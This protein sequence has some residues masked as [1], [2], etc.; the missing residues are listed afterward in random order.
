VVA[1]LR[2]TADLLDEASGRVGRSEVGGPPHRRERRQ[3]PSATA[4]QRA[5]SGSSA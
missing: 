1:I 4:R 5:A 2:A 3:P